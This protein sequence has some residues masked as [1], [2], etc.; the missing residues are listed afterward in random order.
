MSAKTRNG[1]S[2]VR[3]WLEPKKISANAVKSQLTEPHPSK[4]KPI[5]RVQPVCSTTVPRTKVV[6]VHQSPRANIPI[7]TAIIN[8]CAVLSSVKSSKVIIISYH[9]FQKL[10]LPSAAPKPVPPRDQRIA[11]DFPRRTQSHKTSKPGAPSKSCTNVVSVN[12]KINVS[13]N[14]FA[15]LK[16]SNE[17]SVICSSRNDVKS[18]PKTVR[19]QPQ[20]CQSVPRNTPKSDKTGNKKNN[21]S[22]RR[23]QGVVVTQKQSSV[24]RIVNK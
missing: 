24:C 14:D 11:N 15:K 10:H 21:S 7:V 19:V 6:T 2:P 3:G 5:A 17:S 16:L 18:K 9:F 22:S 13:A 4:S 12:V 8:C 23:H 20:S 1:R